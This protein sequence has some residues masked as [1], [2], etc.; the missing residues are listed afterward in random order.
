MWSTKI[1]FF[2]SNK[3]EYYYR[4]II[5]TPC[6]TLRRPGTLLLAVMMPAGE[7]VCDNVQSSHINVK[8]G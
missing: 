2:C 4:F 6:R 3:T 8:T 5:I 1:P 7:K